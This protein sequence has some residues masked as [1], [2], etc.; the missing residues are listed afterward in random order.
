MAGSVARDAGAGRA[1]DVG[2]APGAAHGRGLQGLGD[3]AHGAGAGAHAAGV[4]GAAARCHHGRGAARQPA[5]GTTT[6]PRGHRHRS[7]AGRGVGL[8]VVAVLRGARALV[9][10]RRS[11]M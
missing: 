6:L 10:I 3:G 2:A 7:G 8:V 9:P 11:G 5:P 4:H 1:G